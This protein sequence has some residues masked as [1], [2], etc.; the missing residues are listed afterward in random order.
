M[1]YLGI[2]LPFGL[3]FLKFV[4]KLFIDR[5]INIPDFLEDLCELPVD[6]IFLAISFLIAFTISTKEVG[7][8]LFLSFAY[9]IIAAIIIFIWRRSVNLLYEKKIFFLIFVLLINYS[10]SILPLI[11]SI[12]ILTG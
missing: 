1:G 11:L 7:N 10:L 5:K 9:L 6:M 8:A 2:L 12:N 4:L 3:L